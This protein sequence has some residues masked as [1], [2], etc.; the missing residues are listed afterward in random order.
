MNKIPNL[1]LLNF[2][3]LTK[4]KYLPDLKKRDNKDN[5]NTILSINKRE[6]VTTVFKS[7]IVK[8]IKSKTNVNIK[9]IRKIELTKSSTVIRIG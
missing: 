5:I 9:I 6:L 2:I 4:L 7:L 1:E 3:S 8:N